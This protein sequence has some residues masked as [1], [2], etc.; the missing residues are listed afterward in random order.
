MIEIDSVR[1]S[2]TGTCWMLPLPARESR[3]SE[4]FFRTCRQAISQSNEAPTN[5]PCSFQ[6]W[7]H[8]SESRNRAFFPFGQLW[9]GVNVLKSES[10]PYS[11]KKK[12]Q[13]KK[14]VS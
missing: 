4:Y 3:K 7:T 14:Y 5:V 1:R 8:V 10:V 13:S 6:H 9:L 12:R 11:Q 2:G